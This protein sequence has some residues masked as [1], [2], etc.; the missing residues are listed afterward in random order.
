MLNRNVRNTIAI[1]RNCGVRY[2]YDIATVAAPERIREMRTIES[3]TI[4]SHVWEPPCISSQ[5]ND[6]YFCQHLVRKQLKL[7]SILTTKKYLTDEYT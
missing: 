6:Y 7:L 3:I 5:A 2:S 1:G 4:S